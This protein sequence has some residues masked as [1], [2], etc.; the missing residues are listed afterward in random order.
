MVNVMQEG[1]TLL[2][3]IVILVLL[4][5]LFLIAIP[6]FRYL[7]EGNQ[8][9]VWTNRFSS[10]IRFTRN[11]AISRGNIII[12]C[13]SS[14]QKSCD[15]QWNLGQI[16]IDQ[17]HKEILR[18]LHVVPAGYDLT[19]YSSFGLNDELQF[20]PL[21]MTNGQQGRFC[22]KRNK[23]SPCLAQIIVMG[24]GRIRLIESMK[25]L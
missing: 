2:E 24:T 25:M 12:L 22:L 14:N 15:G 9:T 16:I 18:V 20:T 7:L 21:G 13:G 10:A 1:F 19:W 5:V 17:T 11:A 8:I 4:I 3:I 6:C 23:T